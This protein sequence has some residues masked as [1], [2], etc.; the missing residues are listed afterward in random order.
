MPDVLGLPLIVKPPREGSSI[1]ITKVAGYSRDAGRGRAGRALRRRRAVRGVHRG[2]RA[3][4]PGARRRRAARARCRWCASSR[5]KATTTTRTS[6]SPTSSATSARAACRP[7][8]RRRSSASSLAAYRTLGCRGWGRADLMLRARRP[9]ALPARDEHLA[10]HD[11]A[12]A[13]ADVGARRRHQLRAALPRAARRARPSIP[14]RP[15]SRPARTPEHGPPRPDPPPASSRCPADVRLMNADRRSCSRVVAGAA[16]RRRRRCSGWRASRC[17]RSASSASTATSAATASRP[18]APTPRRAWPATSSRSTSAR[19][20]APSSRCPGCATRWCSGSGRTA[21]AVRLEEHR[22]VALWGGGEPGSEKLVNSFGEVFEANV[23]DVEDDNLPTLEGPDGSSA[24]VL[25]H[26]RQARAGRSRRSR[27]A[28]TR[29]SCRAA[30]RGRRRSTAARWSRS[31][32]A[33]TTRWW[34]APRASSPPCAR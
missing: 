26:A 21:C 12:F 5:P 32:A 9:Q 23:G 29:C 30:A 19:C 33:A 17:S 8:R 34:R 4:L 2:R 24:R 11:H 31:A 13:G 20:V 3:D 15:G 7:R 1:G 14:T 18:S 10:R 22:P 16:A 25:A 27:R 6:T 28:S